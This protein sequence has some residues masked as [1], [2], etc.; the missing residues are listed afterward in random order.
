[1]SRPR[2]LDLFCGAGGCSVGYHRAGFD[3]VGVDHRPQPHYPFEFIQ[4]DA[5]EFLDR[6]RHRAFDAIHASPPCQ[7]Y[8]V[9][10]HIHQSGQ[11]HPDLIDRTRDMLRGT[12]KP[13]VIENVNGAPMKPPAVMLCGMMFGL[14]VLRHRWFESSELL[15]SPPHPKH[16]KGLST[17]TLTAKKGGKGNGYSTGEHGLVCV[18]G[19]NFVRA[20]GAA[21]MGIDWPMTRKELANAIPPAFTEYVGRQL[22]AV[23]RATA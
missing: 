3:V 15:F 2:L 23:A 22:L 9:G 14:R 12:G 21:A 16:P 1:M 4:M 5:V 17:G 18:A 8:T 20:A 10:R 7:A 6:Q 19:N 11:R 13:W